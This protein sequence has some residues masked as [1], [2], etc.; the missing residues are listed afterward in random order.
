LLV[1]DER[2]EDAFTAPG[3]ETER[4]FFGYSVLSCLPSGMLEQPS[5]ATGTVMRRSTFEDYARRA[6]FASVDVLSFEHDF[7]RF[8]RLDR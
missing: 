7:L 4:L 1:A 8:Y 2:T 5:A 3:S 6:G